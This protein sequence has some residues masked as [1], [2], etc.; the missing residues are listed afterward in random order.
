MDRLTFIESS[1]AS[2]DIEV[3]PGQSVMAA[4]VTAGITGIK[5]DCGGSCARATCHCR[6]IVGRDTPLELEEAERNTFE[7][8]SDLMSV[9]SL[10]TCD[11]VDCGQVYEKERG[12][13]RSEL[14]CIPAPP[15][16]PDRGDGS[17][18]C[19]DQRLCS[20]LCFSDCRFIDCP[21]GST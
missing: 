4:A 14:A 18:R 2:Q 17:S 1:G 19:A 6:V 9:T 7:F 3:T 12:S 16:A 21:S 5:G 20:A 10:P 13:A 11:S 15:C 8:T